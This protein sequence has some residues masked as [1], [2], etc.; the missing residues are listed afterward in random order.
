MF[1]ADGIQV[2]LV[3]RGTGRRRI[4]KFVLYPFHRLPRCP[5]NVCPA[6]IQVIEGRQTLSKRQPGSGMGA[7][8]QAV[9]DCI[10]LQSFDDDVDGRFGRKC[11]LHAQLVGAF[12]ADSDGAWNY[13]VAYAIYIFMELVRSGDIK[14]TR[15]IGEINTVKSSERPI[16]TGSGL[17]GI[18]V[19]ASSRITAAA[20]RFALGIQPSIGT[21]ILAGRH[22]EI[23]MRATYLSRLVPDSITRDK[24]KFRW[25]I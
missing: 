9:G 16:L 21:P 19:Q 11:V 10:A 20:I 1:H 15:V 2:G 12:I 8:I 14:R 3:I 6:K 13:L 25:I 23:S 18:P 22:Q 4:A 5:A 7:L 24:L 17:T